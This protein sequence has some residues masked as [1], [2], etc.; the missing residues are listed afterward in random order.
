MKLVFKLSAVAHADNLHRNRMN[1]SGWGGW[2][3]LAVYSLLLFLLI[4]LINSSILE[5]M[6]IR[7]I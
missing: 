3:Y 4:T 1:A 6:Y 7:K 2:L 5:I